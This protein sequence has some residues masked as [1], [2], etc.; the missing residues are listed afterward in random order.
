M[1]M[2]QG[3]DPHRERIWR[4]LAQLRTTWVQYQ[5]LFSECPERVVT[6]NACAGYFFALT[7]RTLFHEVI[8]GIARLTDPVRGNRQT[9]LAI[10]TLL[11]DPSL[12]GKRRIRAELRRLVEAA[13]KTAKAIRVHRHKYVAHLD[14]QVALNLHNTL[15]P[16]VTGDGISAAIDALEAAFSYHALAIREVGIT[17][18]YTN[19]LLDA[20]ALV[21]ILES[22][23]R[24][25]LWQQAR[26]EI[27]TRQ[28]PVAP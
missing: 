25:R 14:E 8:L 28:V 21:N 16:G 18:Y 11:A 19:P 24:W 23:D 9:N 7:Q 15:L 4:E 2:T 22:S 3:V 1:D 17:D 12:K 13:A 20:K 6:L 10:G 27:A 26:T 5:F